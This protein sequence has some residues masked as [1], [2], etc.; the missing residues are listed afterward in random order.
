M[1][2]LNSTWNREKKNSEAEILTLNDLSDALDSWREVPPLSEKLKSFIL[3][4]CLGN[5]I[6]EHLNITV[7]THGLL[8]NAYE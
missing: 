2:T 8:A 5:G 1:Q 6:E 7:S 3:G 4:E